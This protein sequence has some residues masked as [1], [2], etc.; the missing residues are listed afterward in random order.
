MS[1]ELMKNNNSFIMYTTK[2]GKTKIDVKLEND[3]VW[4]TSWFYKN[5]TRNKILMLFF[6]WLV[7][8]VKVVKVGKNGKRFSSII[9][10]REIWLWN[11][12]NG[13]AFG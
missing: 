5:S 1:N 12:L 8:N 2:D 4:L 10:A 13:L 9:S 3:T 6:C 11:I 7:V